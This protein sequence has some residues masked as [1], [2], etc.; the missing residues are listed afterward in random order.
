M[1]EMTPPKRTSH[2]HKDTIKKQDGQE[3][4]KFN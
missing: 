3:T 4:L 1:H 2:Y